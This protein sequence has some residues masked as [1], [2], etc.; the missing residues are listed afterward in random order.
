MPLSKINQELQCLAK[1]VLEINEYEPSSDFQISD[2]YIVANV[3]VYEWLRLDDVKDVCK[4]LGIVYTPTIEGEFSKDRLNNIQSHVIEFGREDIRDNL[5]TQCQFEPIDNMLIAYKYMLNKWD[6]EL[7]SLYRNN[8]TI[9]KFIKRKNNSLSDFKRF[10]K[11]D[12]YYGH[13]YKMSNLFEDADINKDDSGWFYGRS[14]G[15]LTLTKNDN[16]WNGELESHEWVLRQ[17]SIVYG[18]NN[19]E[20]N[21]NFDDVE[22]KKEI[23]KDLKLGIAE[24]DNKVN[25]LKELVEYYSKEVCTDENFKSSLIAQ[26]EH[27]IE[28]FAK[29]DKGTN[30]TLEINEESVKSSLGVKVELTDV[31]ELFEIHEEGISTLK[32]DEIYAIGEKIG[33]YTI[34]YAYNNGNGTII[35]AG[36]HRIPFDNIVEMLKLS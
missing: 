11:N 9:S 21:E 18:T 32:C 4:K 14:G 34:E 13:S 16:F 26:L 5:R 20:F 17:D 33:N 15:W 25:A 23:I 12:K 7:V 24:F 6:H 30:A 10:L 2:G 27:E 35:K 1:R 3:K 19:E 8:K 31:K 22:E 28:E 36:C 29:E